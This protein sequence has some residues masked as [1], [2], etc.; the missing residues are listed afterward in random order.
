MRPSISMQTR[1]AN[2]RESLNAK[3][4]DLDLAW[5]RLQVQGD[6]EW[7]ADMVP[8]SASKQLGRASMWV[9]DWWDTEI[10][11]FST[12]VV[13]IRSRQWGCPGDRLDTRRDATTAP[14]FV[15]RTTAGRDKGWKTGVRTELV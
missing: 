15:V 13:F 14:V 12:F 9:P 1:S 11:F 3:P 7:R 4:A 6:K 5:P 8:R 2:S 10:T